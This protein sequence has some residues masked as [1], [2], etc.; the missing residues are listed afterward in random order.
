MGRLRVRQGAPPLQP[1]KFPNDTEIEFFAGG[2]EINGKGT[3]EFLKRHLNY[4][5]KMMSGTTA[6]SLLT[7]RRPSRESNEQILNSAGTPSSG[8]VDADEEVRARQHR[9]L[10]MTVLH[11][12]GRST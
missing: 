11:T 4:P 8:L 7:A 1:L 9:H 6:H 10:R 3:F 5:P 2:H 12:S